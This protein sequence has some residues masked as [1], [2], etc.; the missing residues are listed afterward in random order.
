MSTVTFHSERSSI[1]FT[2][3]PSSPYV[4]FPGSTLI[5]MNTGS[6]KLM[7]RSIL[8]EGR[9]DFQRP[10]MVFQPTFKSRHCC[11]HKMK[12]GVLIKSSIEVFLLTL[13]TE[14]IRISYPG[15]R[16][17]TVDVSKDTVKRRKGDGDMWGKNDELPLFKLISNMKLSSFSTL[18][19][20][21]YPKQIHRNRY[22]GLIS[23]FIT[24][25]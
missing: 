3:F 13:A 4:R 15:L 10:C 21:N 8:G 19:I 5:F 16:P 11:N 20:K 23:L 9:W 14:L 22:I 6:A 24:K 12:T 25:I 7:I 18:P 17:Q 2:C 1:L